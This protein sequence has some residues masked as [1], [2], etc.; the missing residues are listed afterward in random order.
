MQAVIVCWVMM[1]Y[2]YLYHY[3]RK[4]KTVD[5]TMGTSISNK[6]GLGGGFFTLMYGWLSD[7]STAVFLGVLVTVIGFIM[8]LYFQR[9]KDRRER[10]EYE[11]KK[12][13]LQEQAQREK[14]LHDL[15]V[16]QLLMDKRE[17]DEF[18]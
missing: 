17:P 13:L 15:R 7:T 2:Y 9:K 3:S 10:N 14:E 4:V 12:Q 11:M 1:E 16:K 5:E 18:S 8:S 6:I